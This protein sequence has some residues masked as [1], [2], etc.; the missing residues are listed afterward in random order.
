MDKMKME[1][2]DITAQNIE[3]IGAL[4]PNCITEILDEEKSTAENKVYKK[5]INFEL[6]K[7]MLSKDVVD[8][9]EAYEFT[10]VGKKA[11]IIEAN[12]PIRK[13]LRPCKDESVN[14][15]KT[16]NLYIEGDNLEVLK[17]LQESYLGKVKMI[18]IDPPYNTGNDFIYNDDFKMSS[19]EYA[20]ESGEIDEAGNRMFKNTDSNGRFHSDWCSMIYPRLLLA[21]NLLSDDGVIFISIDDN[22]VE[23]LTKL[24]DEIFSRC[25]R[26]AILVW[27]KKYTGGKGTNTFV[28][29]H[30]YILA[31]AKEINNIGEISMSRPNEEKGKFTQ[32]DIYY[33]ERGMYY[34]RPLKSNLDPRPTLVYPINLPNGESVTTQWICAKETYEELLRD[35]RIEFKNSKSSK[36]PV[37]KKFYEKDGGGNVKIPSFLELS[38]NNEAKEELKELFGITQTRDLPF[39]TPKP[40]KLLEF[41]I[42]N[43]SNNNDVIMD[44]FSGSSSSA[45]ALFNANMQDNAHRKFIMVQL[46]EKTDEASEAY[47][48]GYKNICEIGKERIRRAGKKILEEN[49]DK[50]GIENLDTGFR[51]LK[52]DDTNMRD[53]YYSASEY[54]QDLLSTLESNVKPDRSDLDL[55]FGCLL[56][57]GLPLSLPYACEKIGEYTVH[58]YNDGDL[59]ACFNENIS[60][61]VI[62]EI[63]KK[64][65]LRAV[66]RD[67]SFADSPSKINVAEIFKLLAPDTRVKVI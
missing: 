8:G 44:F 15:N 7:Q 41:F 39:Q 48:A 58:N 62:K 21:R 57:W 20:S 51:V 61:N 59:I 66:F 10:W 25:N 53:V 45:H 17:L 60:E 38:N 16:E 43:F 36:Y 64:R 55:L 67:S 11:S 24:A 37:Y 65:P 29:Y 2:A 4:F 19:D 35:G 13:T 3:K 50:E 5:A 18:Y 49:K 54:S 26:L 40:T 33:E 32:K 52:L 9:N 28:D 23:N 56:E 46:P 27:K 30:E 63:A 31:Y 47:K 6:L 14:W 22:E 1:T 12:K 42:E 34:T